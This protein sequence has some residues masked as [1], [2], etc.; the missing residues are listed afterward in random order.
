MKSCVLVAMGLF[1]A[2]GCATNSNELSLKKMSMNQRIYVGKIQVSFA[3][4]EGGEAPKCELYLN[5]DITPSVR[6]SSDGLVIFKTDRNPFV[7]KSLACYHAASHSRAAWHKQDLNFEGLEREEEQATVK[8]FGDVQVVWKI[9]P[10]ATEEAA[11][12]D[13]ESLGHIKV[14]HVKDSG[15]IKATVTDN[16][17][18]TA[19]AFYAAV[20]EAKDKNY[21]LKSDLVQAVA[22]KSGKKDTQ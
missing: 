21:S 6:I 10:A 13:R 19:A 8:Y 2:V 5:S 17:D 12:N 9:D 16:R 20:P 18:Q 22:P 3:G 15:A 4:V 1:F 14:G 7:L 11:A